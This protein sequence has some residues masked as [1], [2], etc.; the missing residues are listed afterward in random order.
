M[1]KVKGYSPLTNR[2]CECNHY[3]RWWTSYKNEIEIGDTIV[4]KK[5]ELIFSVHKRNTIINY[6]LTL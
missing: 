1:F 3:N 5:G 6:H 2:P 4:K